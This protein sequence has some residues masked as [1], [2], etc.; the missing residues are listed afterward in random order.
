MLGEQ[1]V[2]NTIGE[3]AEATI[4]RD[5]TLRLLEGLRAAHW[6]RPG[7]VSPPEWLELRDVPITDVSAAIRQGLSKAGW[8]PVLDVLRCHNR[9]VEGQPW[10]VA[11]PVDLLRAVE[12]AL[13]RRV[14]DEEDEEPGEVSPSGGQLLSGWSNGRLAHVAHN[15]QRHVHSLVETLVKPGGSDGSLLAPRALWTRLKARA[16]R[17][18]AEAEIEGAL[19]DAALTTARM[20]GRDTERDLALARIERLREQLRHQLEVYCEE[21]GMPVPQPF[22]REE[23]YC[24]H[25]LTA[26][27]VSLAEAEQ[28]IARRASGLAKRQIALEGERAEARLN[29]QILPELLDVLF[30][31]DPLREGFQRERVR[32]QAAMFVGGVTAAVGGLLWGLI[33]SLGDV[34][35][36]GISRLAPV[37][38]PPLLVGLATLAARTISLG[39]PRT[40][41]MAGDYMVHALWNAALTLGATLVAHGCWLY[42]VGRQRGGSGANGQAAASPDTA[43]EVEVETRAHAG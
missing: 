29:S 6:L 31:T 8:Q 24:L 11:E 5:D 42:F 43:Q 38:A 33:E 13:E 36:G 1:L 25:L 4:R 10:N 27:F 23:A 37:A 7:A 21:Q 2:E 17:A 20:V 35:V 12:L 30:E 3:Q 15:L 39:P 34:L 28:I 22:S 14:A 32:H 41:S 19:S 16:M 40:W 26:Y 18:R 9:G